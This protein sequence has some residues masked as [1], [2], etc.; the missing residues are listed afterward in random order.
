MRART[1]MAAVAT[2]ALALGLTAGAA[3]AAPASAWDR[4]ADCES[5]G[6]WSINTGNGFYG[7]LQFTR[8]TWRA[9]G[10]TAYALACRPRQP[11]TAD[12]RGAARAGGPGLGG[13]A[14][15]LGQAAPLR[16]RLGRRCRSPVGTQG[17]AVGPQGLAVGPR[18]LPVD[19]QGLPVGPQ[20]LLV[21]PRDLPVDHQASTAHGRSS[22]CRT[23]GGRLR[24]PCRGLPLLDRRSA[25]AG[26]WVAVAVRAEPLRGGQEPELDPRGSAPATA[27]TR[28]S[29]NQLERK[30]RKV[31]RQLKS[32]G[33]GRRLRGRPHRGRPRSSAAASGRR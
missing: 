12:R 21:R 16:H 22:R 6:N 3:E 10:G 18:G 30:A 27:L 7:G 2:G 25:P 26:R 11:L 17:L 32:C 9:Y 33:H 20:G 14:G 8:S 4:L 28:A 24:G 29:P 15:L 5:G 13:M 19:T 31:A 23:S 1:P